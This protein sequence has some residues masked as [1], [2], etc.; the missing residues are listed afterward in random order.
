MVS[1]ARRTPW[2]RI[3]P[4]PFAGSHLADEGF[5][6]RGISPRQRH[7]AC[8]GLGKYAAIEKVHGKRDGRGCRR[9]IQPQ[10]GAQ[11][12]QANDGLQIAQTAFGSQ[13]DHGLEFRA[14]GRLALHGTIFKFEI[15]LA[16]HRAAVAAA[17][18]HL[19][20]DELSAIH[21]VDHLKAAADG[22]CGYP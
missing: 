21:P 10:A 4:S 1:A 9:G 17:G 16:L 5:H 2:A 7:A 13:V 6:Y 11:V 18:S 19:V 12:V 20:L 22:S 15:G 8:I 14:G 3:R